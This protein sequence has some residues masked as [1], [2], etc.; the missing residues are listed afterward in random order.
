MSGIMMLLASSGGKSPYPVDFLVI[1][2]GGAGGGFG[3]GPPWFKHDV[4]GG[5]TSTAVP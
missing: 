4:M 3:G 2:G 1:A 5:L